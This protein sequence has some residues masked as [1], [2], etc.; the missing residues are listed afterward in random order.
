[1]IVS[2]TKLHLEE[3]IIKIYLCNYHFDRKLHFIAYQVGYLRSVAQTLDGVQSNLFE[4]A[5]HKFYQ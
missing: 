3:Y 5:I 1:M 4:G 2:A